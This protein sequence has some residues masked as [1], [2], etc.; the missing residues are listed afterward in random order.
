MI[1]RPTPRTILVL[2]VAALFLAP[3]STVA[4]NRPDFGED[5]R[6]A[7][8]AW[9]PVKAIDTYTIEVRGPRVIF[10]SREPTLETLVT[11]ETARIVV[12]AY[13]VRPK[14]PE[15]KCLRR[16]VLRTTVRLSQRIGRRPLYDGSFSPPL[17]RPL[18]FATGEEVPSP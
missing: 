14:G 1:E 2:A 10:C 4:G 11:E 5:M 15:T 17:L 8:T 7:R 6:V 16:K 12:D 9:T 13:V 18:P 3:T